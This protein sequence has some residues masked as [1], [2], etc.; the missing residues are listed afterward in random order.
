MLSGERSWSWLERRR[1]VGIESVIRVCA[2]G[3]IALAVTPYLP[4]AFAQD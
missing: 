4:S 1:S 2:P 3:E